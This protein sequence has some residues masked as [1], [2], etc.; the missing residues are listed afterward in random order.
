MKKVFYRNNLKYLPVLIMLS[1]IGFQ[2]SQVYMNE[3]SPWRGGGFG[4]YSAIHH[5]QRKI[6]VTLHTHSG[7]RYSFVSYRGEWGMDGDKARIYPT[8]FHLDHLGKV[9]HEKAWVYSPNTGGIRVADPNENIP[10]QY[11]LKID[12]TQIDILEPK[13]LNDPLNVGISQIKTRVYK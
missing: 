8:S 11:Q 1:V 10:A 7:E 6:Q 12:S 4:M 9:I 13:L 3:L 5:N 2:I